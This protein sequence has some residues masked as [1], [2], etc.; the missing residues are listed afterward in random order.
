MKNL[1]TLPVFL[2]II[3][4]LVYCLN[5]SEISAPVK[6]YIIIAIIISVAVYVFM[7]FFNKKEAL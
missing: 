5:S 2:L 1:K 3:G 6:P 4:F 7:I